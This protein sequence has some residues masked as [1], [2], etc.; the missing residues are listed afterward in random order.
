MKECLLYMKYSI[1]NRMVSNLLLSLKHSNVE[2]YNII[3][4]QSRSTNLG[5]HIEDLFLSH[6]ENFF[7]PT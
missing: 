4:D 2:V 7:I 3:F 6:S 5:L 1:S